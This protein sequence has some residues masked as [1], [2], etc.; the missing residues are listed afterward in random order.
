MYLGSVGRYEDRLKN[1]FFIYAAVLRAVNRASP[2]LHDYDY[3]TGLNHTW[4]AIT[5]KLIDY[6]ISNITQHVH[7]PFNE[8]VFFSNIHDDFQKEVHLKE[9][10]TKFFNISRILDCVSCEK[11]RLNGKL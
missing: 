8:K 11:C 10:Q 5:H 3:R 7:T 2:I 6:M 4:D 1:L 9:I